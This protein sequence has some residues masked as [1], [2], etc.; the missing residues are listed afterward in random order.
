MCH[1][2]ISSYKV[3]RAVSGDLPPPQYL[4]SH[5]YRLALSMRSRCSMQQV[6]LKRH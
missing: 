1:T 4:V 6:S 5:S 2:A 3:T